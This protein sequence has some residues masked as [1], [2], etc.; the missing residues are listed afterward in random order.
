MQ[1]CTFSS[2]LKLDPNWFVHVFRQVDDRFLFLLLAAA[3]TSSTATACS[4]MITL[5]N[6]LIKLFI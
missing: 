2:T 4:L 1:K 5:H 3:A 6:Q